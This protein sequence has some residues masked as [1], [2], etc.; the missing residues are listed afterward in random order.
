MRRFFAPFLLCALLGC[1]ADD[2]D[3]DVADDDDVLDDDDAVDDDDTTADD[4]DTTPD[5]DDATPDDDDATPVCGSDVFEPN[6]GAG[7]AV[8]LLTSAVQLGAC[9][10]DVDWYALSAAAPF[11]LR[12][13]FAHAEG[14]L[15]ATLFEVDGQTVIAEAASEDD[16]ELIPVPAGETL[17]RVA[18][19]L[20]AGDPG[21]RYALARADE[22]CIVDLTEPNS[23][24][25]FGM[26]LAQF[27]SL[28]S[29]PDG[30]EALDLFNL[31]FINDMS[32]GVTMVIEV[33]A[34][35]DEGNLALELRSESGQ[36]FDSLDTN[37]A[38]QRLE[39]VVPEDWDDLMR[40]HVLQT[41][42]AGVLPG[43]HYDLEARAAPP[44]DVQCPAD[45]LEYNSDDFAGS[46]VAMSGAPYTDLVVC[47]DDVDW[48]KL[49]AP[50][51]T[52][53][54]V[55]WDPAEGGLDL[56]LKEIDGTV[57]DAAAGDGGSLTVSGA[58]ANP[59]EPVL[60]RV[61]VDSDAGAF[62][63][64]YSLDLLDLGYCL[65]DRMEPNDTLQDPWPVGLRP[66]PRRSACPGDDDVF[67]LLA[68]A[69]QTLVVD[70]P[71][72]GSE[73]TLAVSLFDP[74]GA[75]VDSVL[76][77]S[78]AASVSSPVR[79]TGYYVLRVVLSNDVGTTPGLTYD[80]NP[81]AE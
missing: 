80:L 66:Y 49:S 44:P 7:D 46:L 38:T 25:P 70:V 56:L 30:D 14:N 47:D 57:V 23:E 32:P 11:E 58:A 67:A 61:Q 75:E 71:H 37:D 59:A 51:G 27:G 73:G 79:A 55:T 35:I 9:E 60:L 3:D 24:Q 18:M 31:P 6:D 63:V 48:F 8:P 41:S 16:D 4:D 54:T 2:D 43:N 29:C 65:E 78:G 45:A 74:S 13:V 10:D 12:V 39:W 52:T 40:L 68:V 28:A 1:P 62:G 72:D 53:A 81:S 5:D 77:A 19:V 76:G 22:P 50:G 33:S 36:L 42:E 64:P 21:S 20:D 69:G 17:L 26:E 34:P 15:D